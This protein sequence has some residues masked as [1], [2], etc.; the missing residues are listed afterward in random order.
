[1]CC[2][3]NNWDRYCSLSTHKKERCIFCVFHLNDNVG[4]SLAENFTKPLF[5]LDNMRYKITSV[6]FFIDCNDYTYDTHK[7]STTLSSA[8]IHI[9]LTVEVMTCVAEFSIL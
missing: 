6:T 5:S 3:Q 8:I 7:Y 2:T 4:K 1:M 9:I